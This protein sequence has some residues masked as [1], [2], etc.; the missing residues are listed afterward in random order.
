MQ[1]TGHASCQYPP[2]LQG[3]FIQCDNSDSAGMSRGHPP[4][5]TVPAGFV[6]TLWQYLINVC[7][8]KHQYSSSLEDM[9][10]KFYNISVTGQQFKRQHRLVKRHTHT[11]CQYPMG[12]MYSHSRLGSCGLCLLCSAA[13][14]VNISS[15][16]SSSSHGDLRHMLSLLASAQE[17]VIHTNE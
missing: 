13:V 14:I 9:Y 10:T 15:T 16:A 6:N 5:P 7:V 17:V 4:V 3:M 12:V 1:G 11:S 8:L 2:S